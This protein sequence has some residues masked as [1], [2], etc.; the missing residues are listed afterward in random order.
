[1]ANVCEI[2]MLLCFGAS[3]PVNFRKA[4]SSGTAKGTSILFLCLIE[5]G[6]VAGI[7]AKILRNNINYVLVF[8]F[9]NL[10]VVAANM[11]LYFA[12]KKKD[13]MREEAGRS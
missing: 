2:L 10:I 6:Y 1:M 5:V 12:N 13:Q 8:Y 9:I 11:V 4:W 3:W 7:T